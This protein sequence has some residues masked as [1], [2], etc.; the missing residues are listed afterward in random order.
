MRAQAY[1][2]EG[3]DGSSPSE[4]LD[5]SPAKRGFFFL[6]ERCVSE[7]GRPWKAFWKN[8]LS[9]PSARRPC[10]RSA[11]VSAPAST[12]RAGPT[13]AARSPG[14]APA[15]CARRS[16]RQPPTPAPTPAYRDRYQRT[17]TRLGKLGATFAVAHPTG[18]VTAQVAPK[19]QKVVIGF[20]KNR[21]VKYFDYGAGTS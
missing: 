19:K 10:A 17:K 4:G 14:K 8:K 2:K 13:D 7:L 18:A 5:E 6:T 21:T 3:V 16:S 1:G 12:S 9:D 15:T 20:Y 11:P